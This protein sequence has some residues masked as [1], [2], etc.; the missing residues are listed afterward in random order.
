MHH[1]GRVDG[2]R[3]RKKETDLLLEFSS[4]CSMAELKLGLIVETMEI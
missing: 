4:V 2:E 3:E 1:T